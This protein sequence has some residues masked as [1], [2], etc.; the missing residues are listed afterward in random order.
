MPYRHDALDARVLDPAEMMLLERVLDIT[1]EYGESDRERDVR[2][3]RIVANYIIGITGEKELIEV[4]SRRRW[5][6]PG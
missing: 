1:A 3:A 4:V 5:P 2:A 6:P